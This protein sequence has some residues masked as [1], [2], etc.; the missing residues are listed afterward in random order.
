[1]SS[2]AQPVSVTVVISTPIQL[3]DIVIESTTVT[4]GSINHSA[5]YRNARPDRAVTVRPVV[6]LVD[7]V[8]RVVL[9]SVASPDIILP[10]NGSQAVSG[11]IPFTLPG[12]FDVIWD[13][14]DPVSIAQLA[15]AIAIA[16][17]IPGPGLGNIAVQT[18]LASST[19]PLVVDF[20]ATV[21]NT[22]S[23][24]EIGI[25][26]TARVRNAAGVVIGQGTSATIVIPPS[27]AQ[28]LQGSIPVTEAGPVTVE[29]EVLNPTTLAP[30]SIVV[31]QL[32]SVAAPLLFSVTAIGSPLTGVEPL[33]VSFSATGSSGLAPYTFDWNFG[34]GSIGTGAA[35]SHTYFGGSHIAVVT[36]RDSLGA[37]STAQVAIT[38]SETFLAGDITLSLP[39]ATSPSFN[40]VNYS[41]T[42]RNN[43]PTLTFSGRVSVDRGAGTPGN[44]H[45]QSLLPLQSTI[46]TGTLLNVPAGTYTIRFV[47]LI[48]SI[49]LAFTTVPGVVVLRAPALGDISIEAFQAVPSFTP[50]AIDHL[51]GYHNVR[52]DI[53]INVLRRVEVFNSLGILVN[54]Q[55][56]TVTIPPTQNFSFF[57]TLVVPAAGTYTVTWTAFEAT[58]LTLLATQSS[59]VGV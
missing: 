54:S 6:S 17:A 24:I 44:S 30:L 8:T 12:N 22:R 40:T 10:P 52:T 13:A 38:V 33:T 41:V 34:D 3:G 48:A 26:L 16:L 53:S 56:D 14:V 51:A 35:V 49:T 1:M 45:G 55:Q 23:D 5:I 32:L 47:A 57:G 20:T 59:L 4:S 9:A 39:S 15:V 28:G 18:A 7:A 37:I 25:A 50:L 58:I 21:V 27:G 29:W 11:I 43:H 46:V 2:L 31:T 42:I 36:A 19:S